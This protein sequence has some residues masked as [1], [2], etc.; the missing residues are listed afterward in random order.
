M[1]ISKISIYGVVYMTTPI[2]KKFIGIQPL[3]DH[4][5]TGRHRQAGLLNRR[6]HWPASPGRPVAG[7]GCGGFSIVSLLP[8]PLPF[9]QGNSGR[10]ESNA[11]KL[12][13]APAVQGEPRN[14][15][16]GCSPV[17]QARRL[18]RACAMVDPMGSKHH[19]NI[20]HSHINIGHNC[21]IIKYIRGFYC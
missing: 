8:P 19:I 6:H 20:G 5:A 15:S 16:L 18:L 1:I 3:P 9:C 12:P 4:I 21:H 14:A 17:K 2:N 7:G 10:E 11:T 13:A